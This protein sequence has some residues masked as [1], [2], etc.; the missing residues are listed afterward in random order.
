MVSLLLLRFLLL[1]I[2]DRHRHAVAPQV[3]QMG[4]GSQ[5]WAV[6]SMNNLIIDKSSQ[7]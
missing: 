7:K 1:G 6:E 5:E 3:A 2:I 4:K